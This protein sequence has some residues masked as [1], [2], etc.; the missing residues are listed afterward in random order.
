[1]AISRFRKR[2]E[3]RLKNVWP[4]LLYRRPLTMKNAVP[5]ISF[6][7]D[8]FLHSALRTGG[9]IL[10]DHGIAGTYY[11]SLGCLGQDGPSGALFD[12]QDLRDLVAKG[13]ELG[14]HTYSHLNAWETGTRAFADSVARNRQALAE[15]VPGAEFRTLSY[16][17]DRPRPR[18]K[19]RV[20]RQFDCCRGGGQKINRG[21]I[22][23]NILNAYFL[24]KRRE[25]LDE[26][27]RLID[28]NAAARGWLIF[29]T[30]DVQDRPSPFGC[31][32]GFFEKIVRRAASSGAAIL[33]VARA[34]DAVDPGRRAAMPGQPRERSPEA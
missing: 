16:P 12:L 27:I 3:G 24:D 13:H 26:A 2:V 30:H 21:T 8:D 6:T 25:D 15:M 4:Y 5:V 18:T 9:A 34:L 28:E 31:R 20:G 7:F 33:P 14:C 23:L 29:A 19:R 10:E 11:A 22:D 32:P 1:M 17:I